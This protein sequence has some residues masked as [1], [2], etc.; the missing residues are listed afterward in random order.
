MTRVKR[1]R[2]NVLFSRPSFISGLGSVINV[3]GNYFEFKYSNS[4]EEADRKAL[5]SDWDVIGDDLRNT[6]KKEKLQHQHE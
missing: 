6:I 5:E 3:A 2:T 4:G 1:Y